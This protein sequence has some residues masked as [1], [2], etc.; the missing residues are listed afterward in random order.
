MKSKRKT[1]I[2]PWR[3][4]FISIASLIGIAII[5]I[6]IILFNYD[7]N[8]LKPHISR[9]VEDATG[10]ELVIGGNIHLQVSL[11][12]RVIIGDIALRNAK[13]GSEQ[14]MIHAKRIKLQVALLPLLFN[15]II[16]KRLIISEPDILLEIS[17][18]G[19]TNFNFTEKSAAEK[20]KRE[21]KDQSNW[22]VFGTKKIVIE[23][24]RFT[25]NNLKDKTSTAAKIKRLWIS[26]KDIQE[27]V[28]LK[29]NGLY[30]EQPITVDGTVGPLP[31]LSDPGEKFTI[32]ILMKAGGNFLSIDGSIQNVASMSGI[33]VEFVS[34]IYN[35]S[36]IEKCIQQP[37]PINTPVKLSGTFALFEPGVFQIP[38][39]SL[40]SH[41]IDLEGSVTLSVKEEQP[42][43]HAEIAAKKLN[44][45]YLMQIPKKVRS[46]ALLKKTKKGWKKTCVSMSS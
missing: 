16:V 4:I 34:K 2:M 22:P 32:H 46:E 35:P 42:K 29:I 17:T 41:D 38:T 3:P 11:A 12:P 44:L 15:E 33:A 36:V 24:G 18:N 27:P 7:L 26:G 8:G 20:E 39:F 40:Q 25:Y 28:R 37:F 21:T 14:N 10:R 1:R 23:N 19:Q 45:E 9:I 5:I 30:N 31:A 6:Y 43:I 13:W